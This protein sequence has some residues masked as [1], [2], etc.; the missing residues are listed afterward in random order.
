MLKKSLLPADT[1]YPTTFATGTTKSLAFSLRSDHSSVS[2]KTLQLKTNVPSSARGHSNNLVSSPAPSSIELISRGPNGHFVVPTGDS[3]TIIVHDYQPRSDRTSSDQ[4]S[5][6]FCLD[7]EDGKPSPFLLSVE[8]NGDGISTCSRGSWVT[9][10]NH[11]R[12]MPFT[13]PVLPH[14]RSS[15]VQPTMTSSTLLLEME[16]ERERGNLN[17]CL[18][19]AQ[20]RE[21]LEKE[22]RKYTLERR[23]FVGENIHRQRSEA[24]G[25][26]LSRESRSNTLPPRHT[27]VEKANV[28]LIPS[29][30]CLSSV[31]WEAE[32]HVSSPTLIP[33][34]NETSAPV[35]R[36]PHCLI[37][38]ASSPA[39]S[40]LT[41]SLLQSEEIGGLTL[42][43]LSSKFGQHEMA[44]VA[45][46]GQDQSPQSLRGSGRQGHS[47]IT[48]SLFHADKCMKRP[49]L[50]PVLSSNTS[51]DKSGVLEINGC[52]EMS[53]DEP[54]LE[55]SVIQHPPRPMLHQRIASHLQHGRP[56]TDLE[57]CGD[58]RRSATF[59][60]RP[61][62]P[63]SPQ[64][65]ETQNVRDDPQ[66]WEMKHRSKSFHFRRQKKS[67]FLTPDAWIISLSQENCSL[68][69]SHYLEPSFLVPRAIGS[70]ANTLPISPVA[71][72]PCP[73]NS[74]E[75]HNDIF[76]HDDNEALA[77]WNTAHPEMAEGEG[78]LE[79]MEGVLMTALPHNTDE[80]V[81]EVEA[82]SSEGM[83]D[84]R[85]SYSSYA[86][87][88]RGSMEQAGGRLSLCRL[89]P[90]PSSSPEMDKHMELSLRY[91]LMRQ[92]G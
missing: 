6:S 15:A 81:L 89:S 85:S 67:N 4:S 65:C 35:S 14:I 82:G 87:S 86:S 50:P 49:V 60:G 59:S 27:L 43:Q 24:S 42:P 73:R 13:F 28:D 78:S 77:D 45:L 63:L 5:A 91:K 69:S 21:E 30:F 41:A 17:Y 1:L 76:Y 2:G 72:D 46:R 29:P 26:R 33:V 80:D 55:V 74:P 70:T 61:V 18:K 88:G 8:P 62:S 20:E 22:L 40:S 54:E 31:H 92:I 53:V 7:Q 57:C 51:Q 23:S 12:A 19:L 52:V 66:S 39:S 9:L 11:N 83:P 48:R 56:H 90:V 25:Y 38:G 3:S 32:T 36:S 44:Q 10:S 37:A 34:L 16:H 68:S 79:E 71:G 84:S 64:F 75:M 58:I 47:S